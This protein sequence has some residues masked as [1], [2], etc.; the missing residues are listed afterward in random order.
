VAVALLD[1]AAAV[2]V[3]ALPPADCDTGFVL[4]PACCWGGSLAIALLFAA[5]ATLLV[6]LAVAVSVPFRLVS[7]G[8]L[9][10]EEE[11][12]ALRLSDVRRPLALVAV[13]EVDVEFEALA[14]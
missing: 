5:V 4:L 7:T 6:A 13:V 10:A 3:G 8:C 14:V 2:A 1:V 9:G 11:K 12:A